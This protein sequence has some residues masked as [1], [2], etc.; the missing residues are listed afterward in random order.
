M[1]R[2]LFFESIAIAGL[3]FVMGGRAAAAAK[4]AVKETNRVDALHTR[5]LVAKADVANGNKRLY[6]RA[7][8][9]AAVAD[10]KAL[11]PRAMYGQMGMP[12]SSVMQLSMASH[13]VTDL[14]M[15]GDYLVAEIELIATPHG[16]ILKQL[17]ETP[18]TVAFRTAGVGNGQVNDDGVLII[19]DSFKLISIN[20]VSV[21]EATPIF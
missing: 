3:G 4:D 13:I 5:C 1:D 17:M 20:A 7:V 15:V 9:E 14:K 16:V 18:D 10:F 8:L 21:T 12:T 6:P 2:R 19:G 11:P